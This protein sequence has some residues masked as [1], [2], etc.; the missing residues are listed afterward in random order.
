VDAILGFFARTM[1]LTGSTFRVELHDVLAN[2][3]HAVSLYV[4]RGKREGRTLEDK[5][6]LVSH[7]RNSRFVETWGYSEDLYATDEFF[8]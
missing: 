4:A 3:E 5:S 7:I 1:E 2:D 6:V 8:S